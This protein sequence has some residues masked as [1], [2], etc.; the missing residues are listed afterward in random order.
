MAE[1]EESTNL[2]VCPHT[3]VYIA[4]RNMDFC[5][6]RPALTEHSYIVFP[7]SKHTC[8]NYNYT[9]QLISRYMTG[10]TDSDQHLHYTNGE[11]EFLVHDSNSI[12]KLGLEFFFCE[13]KTHGPSFWSG[14]S[15]N[16]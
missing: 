6:Y 8:L 4:Y 3:F 12:S 14:N 1:I 11:C 5:P 10:I 15:S 7:N 13:L 9:T 16:E 2:K